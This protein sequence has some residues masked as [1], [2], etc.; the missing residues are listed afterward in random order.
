MSGA[1]PLQ[2]VEHGFV[3]TERIEFT[4]DLERDTDSLWQG[5]R[6]DQREK[7]RRLKREG[8]VLTEGTTLADLTALGTGGRPPRPDATSGDRAT[9]SPPTPRSNESLYHHLV[10]RGAARVFLARRDESV[11]AAILFSTFNHRAYSVFSGSTEAGYKMGT[12]SGLFWTAVE[13][14]KAEGFRQL[15]RG[16]FQ[17]PPR[18]R[19]IRSTASIPSSCGS[20]P[21]PSAACRV[22]RC[23]ALPSGLGA[24]GIGCAPSGRPGSGHCDGGRGPRRAGARPPQGARL[25]S[26]L[27][28]P[29][30][31]LRA[32]WNGATVWALFRSLLTGRVA[33]DPLRRGWLVSSSH[34]WGPGRPC[35]SGRTAIELALRGL[36]VG[37][38][39]EVVLPSFGCTSIVLPVRAVGAAPVLADVGPELNVPLD[40]V[41]ESALTSRT[42]AVIVPHLFGNPAH[43]GG[44]PG[45]MPPPRD[46]RHRRCRAGHGCHADRPP[47]G[48]IRLM[49]AS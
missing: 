42:R 24:C 31:V 7:I 21:R 41:I 36:G 1:S 38:G 2:P 10:H 17:A 18:A 8:V 6:K 11:L 28:L 9:I 29:R 25:P 14:F 26:R 16:G 40:T 35:A 19:T 47:P 15:N 39:S 20:V 27:P 32:Q 46:C 3:E 30:P 33:K 5:I 44:H 13:T 34:S 12:Q 49:P 23:G 4:L 37:A 48:H 45:P 22:T 43:I